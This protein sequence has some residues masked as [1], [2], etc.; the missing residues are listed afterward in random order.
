MYRVILPIVAVTFLACV[1]QAQS[2][3]VYTAALN[4]ASESPSTP[5]PATGSATL[6]LDGDL[7]SVDVSFAGLI[8]GNAAAA[9]IHCCTPPGTNIP[10]AVAFPG[11]PALTSS[12]YQHTFDL[13]QS[14]IYTASFLTNFGGG[15]AAGAEAALIAGLNDGQAYVNI[16]NERFG[17]GEIR[18]FLAAVPEPASVLLLAAGLAFVTGSVRAS[19][20][21]RDRA[22]SH[23]LT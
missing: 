22:G 20:R 3:V 1:T 14:S 13:T 19:R 7:L 23:K 18:G 8:G 4:G 10:V 16:H 5:S 9:H 12:T 15:T 6:T 2:A 17:G 21:N 11:F